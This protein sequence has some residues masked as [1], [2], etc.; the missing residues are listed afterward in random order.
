MRMW[1]RSQSRTAWPGARRR[2]SG[3]H[4]R[5]SCLSFGNVLPLLMLGL[6]AHSHFL[7]D[8]FPTLRGAWK[9]ALMPS[10]AVP[11]PSEPEGGWGAADGAQQA[12]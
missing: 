11:S 4:C 1:G 9:E 6:A 5:Q 2:A 8:S 10:L 7:A 3:P 12:R